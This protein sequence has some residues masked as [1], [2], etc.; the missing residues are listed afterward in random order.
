MGVT[1]STIADP[2]GTKLVIDT[3]SDATPELDVTGAA[4]VIYAVEIDNTA[5]TASTYVKIVDNAAAVSGVTEPDIVLCA[6]GGVK[7]SYMI[8]SGFPIAARLSFWAVKSPYS[9]LADDADSAISPAS[10]V[11]VKI[12]CT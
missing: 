7:Q 5:N 1:V 3:D 8:G 6:G 11:V 12:L 2:L 10:D 9:L 4:T